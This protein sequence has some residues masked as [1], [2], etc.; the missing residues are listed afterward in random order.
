MKKHT[1]LLSI[2]VCLLSVSIAAAQ[3]I[4]PPII[5]NALAAANVQC[6]GV[7]RNQVCYGNSA[8]EAEAQPDAS[9]FAFENVGDIEE[10]AE[11]RRLKLAGLDAE[12]GVWGLA[13]MQIQANIPNTLPGQN[14][15][16]M[17][18]G[19]SEIRNAATSVSQQVPIQQQQTIAASQNV[20][21]RELPSTA[22]RILG[23][24]APGTAITATG[25]TADSTWTR[26]VF[27]EQIGWIAANLLASAEA[28]ENLTPVE[29]EAK[30]F[31][32]MQAFY[33]TAGIGQTACN[34]VPG[35]GMLVQTPA[36]VGSIEL[37]VNE[38]Q[39]EMGSTVYFTVNEAREMAVYSLEGGARVTAGE[40]TRTSVEGTRVRIPLNEDL[41]AASE[42]LEIESYADND[43]LDDLPIDILERDIDIHTPLAD[44]EVELFQ[45]FDTVFDNIDIEDVDEAF[46]YVSESW[47]DDDFDIADFLMSELE[48]TEFDDELEAYFEDEFGD[49]FGD[50]EATDEDFL[51]EDEEDI[52]EGDEEVFDPEAEDEYIDESDAEEFDEEYDTEDEE[53][54]DE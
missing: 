20:N 40:T 54:E 30:Q 4:C 29:P 50:S 7:G 46:D 47:A 31:G 28:S 43:T 12:S 27:G 49:N 35:N 3:G 19:D 16:V 52:L 33:F 17:L 42:P 36:G 22:G 6:A 1:F 23:T 11:V 26:V 10:V 13:L 21:V 45:Q 18:F 2:L 48:Y 44:E 8:L 9:A 32:P 39:V 15:T 5:Q 34:E 24:V 53:D 25:R 37:A 14:V 38:V 51:L 41:V